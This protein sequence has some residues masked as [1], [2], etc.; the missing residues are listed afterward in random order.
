MIIP[1]ITTGSQTSATAPIALKKMTDVRHAGCSSASK[2]RT[3]SAGLDSVRCA[4]CPCPTSTG[5]SRSARG[6]A[7]AVRAA[8]PGALGSGPR[9]TGSGPRASDELRI[10]LLAVDVQNTFCIPGFELFVGGRSGTGAVDDNRRLCEFVYRNLGVITQIVPSLDTHRALQIFHAVWLVDAGRE[11][12]GA[13]HARLGGGRRVGPLARQPGGV[14]EPR[15][16]RDYAERQ[17]ATTRALW[18]RAASTS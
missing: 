11:P 18:P 1:T 14:R 4:S 13:V 17:L 5:R 15:I 16:D 10:C 12:S 2:R 8:R 9:S 7:R 6:V 3:R